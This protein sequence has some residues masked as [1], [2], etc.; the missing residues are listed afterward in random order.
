[1]P[2]L[3]AAVTNLDVSLDVLHTYSGQNG[4]TPIIQSVVATVT[5]FGLGANFSAEVHATADET[6]QIKQMLSD[7]TA[8]AQSELASLSASPAE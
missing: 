6:K 8:R 4:S 2:K 1:M 3:S 5:F 7:M